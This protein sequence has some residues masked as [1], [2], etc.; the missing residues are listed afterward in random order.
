M[1]L[2]TAT[3]WLGALFKNCYQTTGIVAA[4]TA[5]RLMW[6]IFSPADINAPPPLSEFF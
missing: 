4:A 6:A 3:G 5:S 1:Y 2:Y